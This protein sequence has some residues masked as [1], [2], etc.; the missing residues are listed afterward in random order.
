MAVLG[1][2]P[3]PAALRVARARCCINLYDNTSHFAR[4]SSTQAPNKN[5]F[6]D[7]LL[8]PKTSFPL[9]ADPAQ[10]ELPYR[11]R[12]TQELY[13]WQWKNKDPAQTFVLHDGP[14]YA[15]GSLHCGHALN[16]ILKDIINRF[17]VM[18]G[19]RVHYMPGWDCHGLPIENKA[20]Q[21]LQGD[22]RTVP[23]T[24]IR[25]AAREVAHREMEKQKGEFQEF[26]IM[27]DW[28]PDGCYRTLDHSYEIRQLKVL[29]IMVEQGL[30][31]RHHR[32][33]YWSPS[34]ISALAEAELEYVDDHR[35][36]AIHV[37]FPI[38]TCSP[39][40]E[41]I[42]PTGT[43]VPSLM[44]WTTTP[45]TVPSNM[46]VA[47]N[48]EIDYSVVICQDG[49]SFVVAASRVKDLVS[50]GVFGD[51][52]SP[53]L[54]SETI[55]GAELVGTTYKPPF[56]AGPSPVLSAKH[57]TADSGTGLVHTAPAHGPDD[58]AAWKSTKQ[59]GDILCPVDNE[60]KFTDVVGSEWTRLIG[61][62]VLGN[63]NIE[64][65]RI[66]KEQG[67]LVKKETIRH[68][69]P[70]DWKTKKP[71]IFRAT[72]Q[73]FTNLDKI[74]GKALEALKD[75]RF[76][77]EASRARLEA[78]IRERSE[79]CI[80][81][82]RTWG[83]PIPALHDTVTDEAL[84]TPESL[85]H[86]IG[87]LSEKGVN[88]WWDGPV[89]DF[90]PPSERASGRYWRKGT[91]T[92]DVWFDSGSSWSLIRD[93]GLRDGT[94]AD[95]CLEGSDQH[96]GWFQ[97][98]LLT[99]VSCTK[100][101][102][103]RAPYGALITHGFVLDAK[104]KKMS[105]SLGNI[106]SPT[107]IMH[108]GKDKKKEPAYGADVL[109]LWAATVE[110]GK[111][112][113]LSQ[114]VLAQAA[115][116]LRKVR[117]SARFVLGNMG[118][119]E[120]SQLPALEHQKLGLL[121]RYVMNEL[122]VLEKGA[123]EAYSTFN[124]QKIV[125]SVSAFTNNVLSSFYFDI[126]KDTLYAES[127]HGP[128]RQVAMRI[129][130]EILHVLS[131]IVAPILPHLAEEIHAHLNPSERGSVF[132]SGWRSVPKTYDD[133]RAFYD[134]QH[135]LIVR[136]I[137]LESLERIRQ[138]KLIRSALEARVEIITQ[139]DGPISEILQRE[140]NELASLFI[141]SD[142]TLENTVDTEHPWSSADREIVVGT[143]CIN[144]RVRPS[145]G[146]KCPRCW[147]WTAN[148]PQSTQNDVE[149]L[150]GRCQTVVQSI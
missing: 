9:W 144:V 120:F 96:R 52:E 150:C 74:K 60:G 48:A 110:Y 41:R 148:S 28:S 134:M 56:G 116:T 99:A 145:H 13:E 89:E 107:T 104:G 132:R 97:S 24:T 10:R 95:V 123:L 137:V 25:S 68:R 7:T 11:Q 69:Y 34:S 135:V 14:P 81:R 54:I 12:T 76:H 62:E 20:L 78:L 35:S 133:A 37:T 31:T 90:I 128:S 105:K 65:I 15:N 94:Y 8:L 36:Q 27:A 1:H 91:D 45:W 85:E 93:L 83:V 109:R 131:S 50:A 142:V 114:T 42:L 55:T 126:M 59:E 130:L 113:P 16:K 98:L 143:E 136:G 101:A 127:L 44:I 92:I 117:N 40:L 100:D 121:E 79:W 26:G 129:M 141:V 3:L 66:L 140:K 77:P 58:Y 75:V 47:V 64:V 115:E 53:A 124:F 111:D 112:V 118:L 84:L 6:A 21:E 146:S 61:K 2:L 87:V 39:A 57:V 82:Q 19:H 43:N 51:G 49:R 73:W 88:H 108:G 46:A 70:Y 138:E 33:V 38:Q 30:I 147:K 5:A 32:P 86:I 80:S 102:K 125:H 72:S 23:A 122:Y 106:I 4:F 71:V 18:Q 67:L 63:G 29:Q 22:A 119:S 139:G 103:L 17:H 149:K